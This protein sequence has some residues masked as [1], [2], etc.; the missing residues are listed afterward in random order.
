MYEGRI[1]MLPMGVFFA[2]E[3]KA[4]YKVDDLQY[5][6][7]VPPPITEGVPKQIAGG[8]WWNVSVNAYSEYP[9]AAARYCVAMSG[10]GFSEQWIRRTDNPAGGN[11]NTEFVTWTTLRRAYEILSDHAATW[12]NIPPAI[13]SDFLNVQAELVASRLSGQDAANYVDDL[14]SSL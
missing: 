10:V 5:S 12:F 2:A 4:Q 11:V 3:S 1:G 14:F 7:L 8:L 13:S 9:E 6:I